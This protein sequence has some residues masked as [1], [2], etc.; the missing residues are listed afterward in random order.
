ML[1]SAV[2]M[3]RAKYS[4]E[5]LL[6]IKMSS[7]KCGANKRTYLNTRSRGECTQH[8]MDATY[9]QQ[10]PAL[11]SKESYYGYHNKLMP[12]SPHC[13]HVFIWMCATLGRSCAGEIVQAL[14][15]NGEKGFVL[16][17]L[18]NGVAT[19]RSLSRSVW[20]SGWHHNLS[21]LARTVIK[22]W[23]DFI[24]AMMNSCPLPVRS[25]SALGNTIKKP[26]LCF[27]NL[28]AEAKVEWSAWPAAAVC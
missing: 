5:I 12:S 23:H 18:A 21:L 6:G 27:R 2:R 1:C 13:L 20:L 8:L 11:S 22:K 28:R 25:Q 10:H 9:L 15:R 7:L 24:A 16:V 19:S 26:F 14:H 4:A 3:K 17:N